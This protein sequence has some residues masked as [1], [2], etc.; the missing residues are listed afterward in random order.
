M[1]MGIGFSELLL[2][3]LLVL[4]FFGSKEFPRF[5]REGAT[6]FARMRSYGEKVRR[7][8]NEISESLEGVPRVPEDDNVRIQKKELRNKYLVLRRGLAPAVRTEKS[9]LIRSYL[10]ESA[11]FRNAE[12]IMVYVSIG[13]EVETRELI[14]EMV[15]A[16]KRVLV[17]YS[18]PE[19]RTM[20]LGEIKD[21]DKD[22]VIGES[23]VPEPA[24]ELRDR[25]FRSD[26]QLIVCPGVCFDVYGGRL[27]RGRACYDNFLRELRGRIPIFGLAFDF[28]I[29]QE[30]L[31]FSYSDV[32]MDQIVTE[33]GLKLPDGLAG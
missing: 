4:V 25:F 23:K 24:S 9:I 15:R 27:G 28:Q 30:R 8:L 11:R 12:A 13:S 31:P 14:T 20:G 22:V 17:P 29:H 1:D 19:S 18:R 2:I 21:L 10:K 32:P 5:I 16:G 33:T 7:E 26:L 6:L 3:I